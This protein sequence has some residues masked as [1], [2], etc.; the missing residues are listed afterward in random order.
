MHQDQVLEPPTNKSANGLLPEGVEPQVWGYSSH[1]KVQGL[2]IPDRL[3]ST[4]AH[5]AFDE[6]MVKRQI[7]MR[8]D[9]GSITDT[10]HADQASETAHLDHDGFQ[11]AAA[12]LRLFHYDD[13]GMEW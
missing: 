11:V 10:E 6:S 3:F 5:L 13:D 8:I 1:T 7:Q 9:A 4:Q 2:Y 12:I